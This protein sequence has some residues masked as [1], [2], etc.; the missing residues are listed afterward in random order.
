MYI[1]HLKCMELL[2][3]LGL[4]F[5]FSPLSHSCTLFK[6]LCFALRVGHFKSQL[7]RNSCGSQGLNIGSHTIIHGTVYLLR[8]ALF[9]WG[10]WMRHIC[11][12]RC[13][14]FLW[15]LVLASSFWPEFSPRTFIDTDKCAQSMAKR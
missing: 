8:L 5:S 4:Y 12:C 15:L 1:I 3:I 11:L 9:F 13:L 2:F 14:L 10:R 7:A 6:D